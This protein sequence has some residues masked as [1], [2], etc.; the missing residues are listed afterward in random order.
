VIHPLIYFGKISAMHFLKKLVSFYFKLNKIMKNL[1]RFTLL[2]TFL[3]STSLLAQSESSPYKII[4]SIPVKGDEKWDFCSIDEN[5]SRLYISHTSKVQVIDLN[6][7]SLL[8]EIDHTSGV[9]GIAIAA[10]L[11]KGFISNGESNSITVFDL[12]TL[13]TLTDI[14]IAGKD[15]DAIIYVTKTK[16]VYAF[17]GDTH[18]A[19]V[20]DA[21]TNAIVG[22]VDL[23]GT[24]EYAVEGEN[25]IIYDNI[26]DKNEL[27]LINSQTLKVTK[28]LS[29]NPCKGPTGL[30]IDLK[31]N[32][33]FTGCRGNRGLSV[34]N[35]S[36]EKVIQTLSIGDHVDFVSFDP[37]TKIVFASNG[38]GTLT[39]IQQVDADHYNILQNL[40]TQKGSK[41]MALD[42]KTHKV[43]LCAAEFGGDKKVIKGT[44]KILV[45]ERKK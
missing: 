42:T 15:P 22:I 45:V 29:L 40:M 17:C 38:D 24:P 21:T 5:A 39:I 20:I 41:T 28:Y 11:G 16:Q 37:E 8:G 19:I 9:H 23:S 7:D 3:Y 26:E 12:K 6:G 32:R 34:I 33:L 10:N 27:A 36:T 25:G 13:K 31:N 4:K 35:I 44:F 2:F 18:N 14:K 43:Y 1:L 30:A